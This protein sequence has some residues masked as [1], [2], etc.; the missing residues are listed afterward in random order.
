VSPPPPS[1]RSSTCSPPARGRVAAPR[2][3]RAHDAYARRRRWAASLP[4]CANNDTCAAPTWCAALLGGREPRSVSLRLVRKR[5][6]PSGRRA[7]RRSSSAARRR[8]RH[9]ASHAT[10]TLLDKLM[11][12]RLVQAAAHLGALMS[13]YIPEPS[14]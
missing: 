5:H 2:L 9:A 12:A 4:F 6:D 14:V 7:A 3:H 1:C 10:P 8:R 13:E 11:T